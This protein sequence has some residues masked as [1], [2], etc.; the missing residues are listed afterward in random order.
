MAGSS[1]NFTRIGEQ[2]FQKMD[3]INAEVFTLTYGSMVQQLLK[4][5]ACARARR[6]APRHISVPPTLPGDRRRPSSPVAHRWRLSAC[7]PRRTTRTLLR[8]ATSW[9]RWGMALGSGSSTSCW[10][11]A[12][13]D[14]SALTP[15]AYLCHV[16]R[17]V[18][19]R[20]APAGI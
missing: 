15:A 13:L 6:L 7:V 4:V 20:L 16:P 14:R 2:A 10:R 5:L 3:K 17:A 9:I 18:S 19:L 11:K 1:K 8:S 12:T